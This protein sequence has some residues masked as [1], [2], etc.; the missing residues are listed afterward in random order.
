MAQFVKEGIPNPLL[1]YPFAE[2]FSTVFKKPNTLNGTATL[3]SGI[4]VCPSE[5]SPLANSSWYGSSEK[6]KGAYGLT[7]SLLP[8]AR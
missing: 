5:I 1:A 7:F 2:P 3:A 4:E 6:H 8:D